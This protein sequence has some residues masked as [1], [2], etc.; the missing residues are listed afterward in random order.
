M[1]DV[2]V[3]VCACVVCGYQLVCRALLRDD[4]ALDLDALELCLR[5]TVACCST[6]ACHLAK[7]AGQDHSSLLRKVCRVAIACSVYHLTETAG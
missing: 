6:D 3:C 1:E 2:R 4:M 5:V 7:T